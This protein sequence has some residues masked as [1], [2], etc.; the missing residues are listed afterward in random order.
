MMES[1]RRQSD[2]ITIYLYNP[3][4]R[5][6]KKAIGVEQFLPFHFELERK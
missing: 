4:T 6:L 5:D 3:V 1:E 2:P